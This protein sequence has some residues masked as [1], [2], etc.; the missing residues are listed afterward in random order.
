VGDELDKKMMAR[1]WSDFIKY[2]KKKELVNGKKV[3]DE[4]KDPFLSYK[5]RT[6]FKKDSSV[7]EED[8]VFKV[9]VYREN[10]NYD[11]AVERLKAR[12]DPTRVEKNELLYSELNDPEQ[13]EPIREVWVHGQASVLVSL[14][15]IWIIQGKNLSMTQDMRQ[16]LLGK[17][18]YNLSE[19]GCMLGDPDEED[20][21]AVTNP[22]KLDQDSAEESEEEEES[23]ADNDSRVG[24][25]SESA[26]EEEEE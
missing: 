1:S 26:G 13:N 24:D 22:Q 9:S 10:D 3:N 6:N 25:K 2:P 21:G 11:P 5:V 16:I 8:L 12:D 4:E 7:A 20:L 23:V 17:Q 19:F 18:Q 15:C 14:P